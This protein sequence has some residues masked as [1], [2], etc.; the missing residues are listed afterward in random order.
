M[1]PEE[2]SRTAAPNA[3][4]GPPREA[5]RP[6]R[7][8]LLWTLL[9]VLLLTALVPLFLTAYK[10]IDI[11]KESLEAA[12][13]EYQLEV[14]SA[15]VQDLNAVTAGANNQIAATAHYIQARIERSAGREPMGD[16]AILAPYVTGDLAVLRY[17]SREGS[18]LE[19]GDRPRARDE[20][21]ASSMFEAFATAMGGEPFVGRPVASVHP[22][23]AKRPCVVVAVPVRARGEVRGVLAGVVDLSASWARSVSSLGSNYIVFALDD[24]GKLFASAEMPDAL[25]RSDAYRRLEIVTRFR[26]EGPGVTEIIPFEAPEGLQVKE[27]LGARAATERGWGIFVIVDRNLAYAS[28]TEMRRSVYQWALFAVGLAALSAI[29]FAGAITRPLKELV[30]S[31]RRLAAGDFSARADVRSRNE[32]GE[33]ADTFN[34]MTEEIRNYIEKIKQASE[35]NSQLFLGTIKAL[36]AAIDEK[37]PY[38][39]GH[40]ERVHRYSVAIAKHLGLSKQE[41]RNIT[42]GALLHDVGKIGIEDAILRKPAALSDKEF[43]IMKRHPLKGAHILGEMP[44]MKDILPAMRSHHERWSGGGY[45]DNLKGEQIP[46]LARIVQVADTFDAMTTNRP[47]QRAMRMD[48]AVARIQELSEIVFDPRVVAAFKEAW[49]GGE[50][51]GDPEA[52][53]RAETLVKEAAG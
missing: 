29:A 8:R 49:L 28:V 42:V 44:Q 46:M 48:A 6:G 21:V 38:T 5:L 31:A 36:A 43:E 50:L 4:A 2:T 17:T 25:T 53:E 34:F 27:L 13:R 20:S 52:S 23:G 33:L 12:T 30:S 51:K 7:V 9:A 18:M 14:A 26:R 15:I 11:T 3:P 47:Y 35:E 32:I 41:L 45:P 1:S 24:E 40:S 39:R 10:L 22:G 19:V 37:D 16:N